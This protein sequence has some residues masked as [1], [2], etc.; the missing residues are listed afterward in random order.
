MDEDERAIAGLIWIKFDMQWP[1]IIW[2]LSLKNII[3]SW[4]FPKTFKMMQLAA[5]FFKYIRFQILLYKLESVNKVFRN[6][7]TG[8]KNIKLKYIIYFIFYFI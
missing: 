4:G 3:L 1:E 6:A 8:C 5:I 7:T 2:V